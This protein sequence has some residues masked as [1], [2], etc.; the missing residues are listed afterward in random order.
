MSAHAGWGPECKINGKSNDRTETSVFRCPS[1][2]VV[3]GFL[4][5]NVS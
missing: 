4:T 3:N 2:K 5:I 1:T